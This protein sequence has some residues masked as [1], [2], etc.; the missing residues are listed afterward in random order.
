MYKIRI[1]CTE[2]KELSFNG[3]KIN[4]KRYSNIVTAL[5]PNLFEYIDTVCV[6]YVKY[7]AFTC[8]SLEFLCNRC[9]DDVELK[10]IISHMKTIGF[11]SQKG[12]I[13]L[14]NSSGYVI[15]NY[16]F[17]LERKVET[18]IKPKKENNSRY[19]QFVLYKK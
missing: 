1:R 14:V 8:K 7:G 13:Q 12:C 5:Q 3:K 15:S 18:Q 6:L 17:D 19:S 4:K 16:I 2:P 11:M 9:I 10:Y